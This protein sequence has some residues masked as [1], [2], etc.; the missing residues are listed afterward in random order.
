[1]TMGEDEVRAEVFEDHEVLHPPHRLRKA[2]ASGRGGP[3]VDLGAIARAE[4]ALAELA[5]EFSAWMHN[6]IKVLDAAR[7]IV[8]ERGFD[9]E[10]RAALFRA[11]HDIR[12]EAATF[13][14]PLAGQVAA[15][16][17]RILEGIADD[18]ALPLVLVEQHV[19]AIR[20][21]VREDVRGE[22][23]ATARL[24]ARSLEESCETAIRAV[25]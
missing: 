16:L 8:R 22:G 4:K 17:C 18:R 10:T 20:A 14:Y 21:M 7:T 24:L 5:V 1:M 13:G 6:E 3:A 23:D 25:A 12:G 2:I 19:D 9:K 15:S 11:A